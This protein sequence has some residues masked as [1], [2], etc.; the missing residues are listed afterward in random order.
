MRRT[1]NFVL[2]S[3]RVTGSTSHDDLA[4]FYSGVEQ[5]FRVVGREEGWPHFPDGN[6][7]AGIEGTDSECQKRLTAV[8]DKMGIPVSRM[9]TALGENGL[10]SSVNRSIPNALATGKLNIV[11]NAFVREV[12]L[13]RTRAAPPASV[14]SVATPVAKCTPP[15]ASSS[16]L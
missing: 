2:L 1:E 9:R 7:V 8:A 16:P 3:L 14:L 10:A 4:P 5:Q 11:P 13:D 15:R 6:F 12:T